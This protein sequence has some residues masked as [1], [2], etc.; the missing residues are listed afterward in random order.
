MVL[1]GCL[2][3]LMTPCSLDILPF[4]KAHVHELALNT[5][6]LDDEVII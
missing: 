2:W 4:R 6:G 1:V 3:L 5:L